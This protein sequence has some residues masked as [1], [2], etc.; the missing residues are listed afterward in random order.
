MHRPHPPGRSASLRR[1]SSALAVV[2]LL[3]L[4]APPPP[5]AR[6]APPPRL[7]PA[8][9]V[10]ALLVL[11]PPAPAQTYYWRGAAGGAGAWDLSPPNW[12]T[13]PAGTGDTPWLNDGTI[14]AS[15]GGV[16]G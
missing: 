16:G 2:G 15:F 10:V 4:A 1:L 9:P 14:A 6:P 5:P 11:A 7:P 8:L 12:G 3:V 13:A